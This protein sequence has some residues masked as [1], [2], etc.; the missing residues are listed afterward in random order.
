MAAT[1]GPQG[2]H[3]NGFQ[4]EEV[5]KELREEP[6]NFQFF[7]AVRLLERLQTGLPV[8]RFGN[9]EQE[10][11]RFEVN[12]ALDFPPSE[13]HSLD[14]DPGQQ[15]RM[16]VNFFGL[17][18][19]LGSLPIPYTEYI[20]ERGRARDNTLQDFLD[21]FHHRFIS[22]FYSAWEKYRFPV[23][24]ERDGQDRFTRYLL[25]FIG[26]GTSGLRNRL[27][28]RDDAMVYYTGLLA[29]QPRSALALRQVLSDY[30]GVP[31]EVQQFIGA[32]YPLSKANQSRVG[33]DRPYC[34][35]VALGAVAGDEVWDRQGRAR[36]VL[37]PLMLEQ[38]L[39]FLP[40]G[41]AYGPLNE[42]VQFFSRRAFDFELQLILRREE[43]P[44][45]LLDDGEASGPMLGWTT[46]M[47]SAPMTRD[48]GETVLLLQ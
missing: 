15:P 40:C 7:Q 12:P 24:F 8:G 11:V 41:T 18:G 2:P 29:L 35:Q 47:K 14:W 3:V 31:V 13:I 16:S 34:E 43:T 1:S 6:W 30:F 10:A 19:S 33:E 4:E 21:I 23:A 39:D 37:G 38:Y 48:P 5:A 42:M 28:I 46:W 27:S 45:V 44:R 20:I 17:S 22:L 26:L 25:D 36:V 9:P 32:W